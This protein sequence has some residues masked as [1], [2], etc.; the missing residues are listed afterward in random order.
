MQ[1]S[2]ALIGV[3]STLLTGLIISTATAETISF[4]NGWSLRGTSETYTT[5]NNFDKDC[6]ELIWLFDDDIGWKV[7]SPLP[8]AQALIADKGFELLTSIDKKYG[9]WALSNSDCSVDLPTTSVIDTNNTSNTGNVDNISLMKA[10]WQTQIGSAGFEDVRAMAVDELGHVYISGVYNGNINGLAAPQGSGD[11]FIRKYSSEGVLLWTK[12][13]NSA[14]IETP[15]QLAFSSSDD[16]IVMVGFTTGSLD[17]DPG[18]STYNN[19]GNGSFIVKLSASDGSFVNATSWEDSK[20]KFLDLDI[21][22]TGN[23]YLTGALGGLTNGYTQNYTVDVNP[24]ASIFKLVTSGYVDGLIVKLNASLG[25]VWAKHEGSYNETT[26]FT[27]AV[28]D[29]TDHIRVTGISSS[30]SPSSSISQ[31]STRKSLINTYDI[32]DGSI[33]S[34]HNLSYFDE[35][36]PLNIAVTSKGENVVCGVTTMDSSLFSG[37]ASKL[38]STVDLLDYGYSSLFIA[39]FD[40]Y[41]NEKWRIQANSFGQSG[42]YGLDIDA[43]DNIIVAGEYDG[44]MKMGDY[45]IDSSGG[46]LDSFVGKVDSNGTVLGIKSFGGYQTERIQRIKLHND[47]IYASGWFSGLLTFNPDKSS[48]ASEG[49]KDGF[50]VKLAQ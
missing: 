11:V 22:S 16:T 12:T 26:G 43:N 1:N 20:V 44:S 21:D 31:Y 7:Y 41:G 2:K 5:M 25:F 3:L 15:T 8:N 37:G 34:S 38:N 29:D 23:L 6:V 4:K 46:T 42:C 17:I 32:S 50:I 19:K 10:T 13:L 14:S 39:K 24:S 27:S 28:L 35:A 45:S 36:A 18:I 47:S 30:T 9:F 33:A 48:L 49:N 40:S